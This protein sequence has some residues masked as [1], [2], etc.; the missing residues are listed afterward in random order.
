[1]LGH[2]GNSK[3][4]TAGVANTAY[5]LLVAGISNSQMQ[6]VAFTVAGTKPSA[7]TIEIGDNLVGWSI[8]EIGDNW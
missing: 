5:V 4:R 7:E 6:H 8:G 1:M 3:E 2:S